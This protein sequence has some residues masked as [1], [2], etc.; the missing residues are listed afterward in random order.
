MLWIR[1]RGRGPCFGKPPGG[2]LNGISNPGLQDFHEKNHTPESDT[3]FST[4]EFCSGSLEDDVSFF[5]FGISAVSAAPLAERTIGNYPWSQLHIANKGTHL[6]HLTQALLT[7]YS[8]IFRYMISLAIWYVLSRMEWYWIAIFFIAGIE[9]NPP[10]IT[11]KLLARKGRWSRKLAAAMVPWLAK[12]LPQPGHVLGTLANTVDLKVA[13]AQW[14]HCFDC[15]VVLT[16]KILKLQWIAS[17]HLNESY[18]AHWL[19]S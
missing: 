12:T 3:L 5:N 6:Q 9:C 14:Y 16:L 7:K 18:A 19:G 8:N 11:P 15:Y 17:I 1:I 13:M 10:E 4:G 2:A